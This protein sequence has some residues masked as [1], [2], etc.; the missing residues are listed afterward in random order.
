MAARLRSE[1][2]RWVAE[3]NGTGVTA[4]LV[5]AS[6]TWTGAAGVDGA[7]EP[8]VPEAAM[9]IASMTKTFVA[10]EVLLLA[11]RGA[12][13][14]E[15]PVTDYVALPFDAGGATVREV[16][17][18]RSGFPGEP[19]D[20]ITEAVRADP[21]RSWAP[22]EVLALVAPD[23]ARVGRRGGSPAYNNVNY[24][25]L[26]FLV[27]EVTGVPLGRALRRDLIEPARL[28]RVWMQPEESPGPPLAAPGP[29]RWTEG[30][31][32]PYLPSRA[33]TSIARGAGAMAGDAP[34]IARWA[35]LLYGGH[36]LDPT[37]VAEMVA[38]DE[39]RWAYGLGTMVVE[40]DGDRLVGHQGDMAYHGGVFV[41]TQ[42][43]TSVAVLVP[44]SAPAHA[45]TGEDALE[46]VLAL[47]LAADRS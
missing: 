24:V 1:L 37:L 25:V 28:S 29:G 12:V 8:L 34:T 27:E 38:V 13:D 2:E 3:G 32:G 17:A 9:G 22:A 19:W 46:L 7:G 45:G 15:A 44:H 42:D 5:S 11:D 41:S 20:R 36:V 6:G 4:A 35:Y 47:H 26:G 40:A 16:L 31:A 21:D 43:A 33:A 10:A 30:Q 18:M 14:L 23:Y 39:G